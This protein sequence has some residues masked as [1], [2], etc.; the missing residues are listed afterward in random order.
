M[1]MVALRLRWIFFEDVR[2]SRIEAILKEIT[3]KFER[4]EDNTYI[5]VITSK[6]QL[7]RLSQQDVVAWIDEP[8]GPILNQ[9]LN[10]QSAVGVPVSPPLGYS[11]SGV[12][13]SIGENGHIEPLFHPSFIGRL[14][15]AN[16]K[17]YR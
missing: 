11:G 9:T 17:P 10:A 1:Q 7:T 6:D 15:Y 12:V 3:D 13:V 2:T 16:S 8:Q 4:Q 14:T 5:V